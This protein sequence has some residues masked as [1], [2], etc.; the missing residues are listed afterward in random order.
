MPNLLC[1]LRFRAVSVNNLPTSRDACEMRKHSVFLFGFF[2]LHPESHL[3]TLVPIY[4]EP[5]VHRA[6]LCTF[7]HALV[8]R[9]PWKF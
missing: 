4:I 7:L 2:F 3:V 6:S 8:L 9:S 5:Q 1:A